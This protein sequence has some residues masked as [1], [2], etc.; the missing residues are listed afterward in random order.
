[1]GLLDYG[2]GYG[3]RPHK[4]FINFSLEKF[5]G[6]WPPILRSS[7]PGNVHRIPTAFAK[8]KRTRDVRVLFVPIK[9]D[10]IQ[11]GSYLPG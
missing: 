3:A 11:N 4:I 1:M 7:R 2:A 8:I 9:T 5:N 6:A 10:P